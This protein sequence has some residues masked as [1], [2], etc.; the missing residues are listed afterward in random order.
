ML[1]VLLSTLF[2]IFLGVSSIALFPVAVLIW[3]CT[4][5][6]DPRRAILHRFTCFWASLYTWLNPAW[7]VRIDG[8]ERVRPGVTYV[9]VA[10]HQSFL[11]I[12]VL[13]RLFVHFKWVSKIEIFSVPLIGWNMS[14]NRYIRL[15]RGDRASIREMMTASEEALAGGSSIMMFPEGTRSADGRLKPFKPG[16]FVLAKR[17]AGAAPADR[18]ARARRERCRSAASSSRADIASTSDVRE[19][20]P[21]ESFAD[22]SAEELTERMHAL[23]A[24]E[25]GETPD[26]ARPRASAGRSPRALALA[27]PRARDGL[28]GDRSRAPSP[29]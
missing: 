20:I 19:E 12:L 13:F 6:F 14:L 2:W 23:F 8:R 1:R 26:E 21:P 15:K 25:L 10:N 3:L 11:D 28:R 16:A 9:M 7:P 22:I 4:A 5:P 24:A 27:P 17:D 18:R 29:A